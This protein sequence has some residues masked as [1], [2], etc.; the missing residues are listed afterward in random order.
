MRKII[1]VLLTVLMLA[2]V[3]AAF[4]ASAAEATTY[5]GTTATTAGLNTIFISEIGRYMYYHRY[6]TAE[7]KYGNAMSFVELYNNG[8]AD[9]ELDNISLVQGVEIDT[10]PKNAADPYLYEKKVGGQD[11]P[12]WREWRDSYRFISKMDLKSGKIIEDAEALKYGGV[13]TDADTTTPNVID[14][15]R[16]FN[17]L[18]NEGID[19]TF[20]SGDNVAI[21]FINQQTINWMKW[22]DEQIQGFNP[23]KEFVTN[24]YGVDAAANYQ[25]YKILMV[26]A[27]SDYT[28]DDAS[29]LADNMFT[30]DN[31]PDQT[32][33]TKNFILGVADSTWNI[34]VDQAYTPASQSNP[35]ASINEKL[36]SMTVM[37]TR[38]PKYT[39]KK[40]TDVASVFA[41]AN[42]TPYVVNAREKLLNT[43]AVDKADYF[44]AGYVESYR[45]VGAVNWTDAKATPGMMPAWQWA[46]IDADHAKAPDSLKT[47][48][49]KDATKVKAAIDAYIQECGLVDDGVNAGRDESGINTDYTD[50]GPSQEELRDIFNKK[51]DT[52]T[53][54]GGLSPV[55]LIII[56]VAAV[57]VVAGGACAVVF[58]VILPKKKA[59]AAAAAGDAP[60]EDA[61]AAEENDTPAQE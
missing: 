37:G 30:F 8:T 18:T 7:G 2:S 15:D 10:V 46:M 26:W 49:A 1:A 19:M 40:M 6:G 56:I 32:D 51:K 45:E 59:A 41:P 31:V 27:W 50:L 11:R 16:I 13:F 9:V 43:N 39:G 5:D 3:L 25:N 61:P 47:E 29:V 24:Y 48:G 23:R 22:C 35:T 4:P 14:N 60:A 33:T 52:T 44:A 58:L 38:V 57:L 12:L 34:N 21:W 28:V 42:T 54:D 17:A 53:D 55:V 20:T 36:Y